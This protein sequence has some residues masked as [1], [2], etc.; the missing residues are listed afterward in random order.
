MNRATTPTD[1]PI[2]LYKEFSLELA[3][4]LCSI[5]NASLSQSSVPGDWKVSY[6]TPLPKTTNPQSF[7]DLRPVAITPIAS[8]LC[9]DFVFDWSYAEIIKHID[10]Q[11]FGNVKATSTSHYLV[12]ILEF[13]HSHLDKRD[14]SLALAFVD[15]KK[16]FDL[17]DHS[18]VINK[19]IDL[20]L[21]PDLISSLI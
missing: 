18:V 2:K 13:I 6:V 17:V 16:A 4:P 5:I 1:L 12:N 20:G 11:Q 3:T 8:L 21:P 15:F 7:N 9:E 19:A 14:T 10:T